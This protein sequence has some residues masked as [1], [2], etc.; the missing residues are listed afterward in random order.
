MKS[1]ILRLVFLYDLPDQ[2]NQLLLQV[3]E[4]AVDRC[5]IH[6]LLKFIQ[7]GI[8]DLFVRVR[9]TGDLPAHLDHFPEMGGVNGIIRSILGFLPGCS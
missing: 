4:Q 7:H 9:I 6:T 5:G 3:M 8:V 2:R 1:R